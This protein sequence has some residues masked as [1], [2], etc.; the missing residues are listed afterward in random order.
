MKITVHF[1]FSSKVVKMPPCPLSVLSRPFNIFADQILFLMTQHNL[2]FCHLVYLETIAKV[3]WVCDDVPCPQA[4]GPLP[5]VP[6]GRMRLEFRESTGWRAAFSL[7]RDAASPL[8]LTFG[9]IIANQFSFV[10]VMD[11]AHRRRDHTE[12]PW[13][14]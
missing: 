5:S 4:L 7:A 10:L 11:E 8:S 1:H 12:S 3:E 9:P 6:H 14:L 13:G 2:H